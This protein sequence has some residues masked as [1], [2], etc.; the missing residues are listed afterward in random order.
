MNQSKDKGAHQISG[1]DSPIFDGRREQTLVIGPDEDAA[2]V[3]KEKNIDTEDI[4]RLQYGKVIVYNK[5]KRPCEECNVCCYEQGVIALKKY[6]ETAC[7]NSLANGKCRIYG[8]HPR[9]CQGYDCGHRLG[10]WDPADRPDKSGVLVSFY[11]NPPLQKPGLHAVV[12]LRKGH[13]PSRAGKMIADLVDALG[14]VKVLY[15]NREVTLFENGKVTLGKRL[16]QE[17]GMYEDLRIE[18][19]T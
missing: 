14:D 18:I 7:V 1:P 15:P 13:N 12:V 11:P 16:P 4:R 6:A 3:L 9:A 8:F 19:V 17:P 10:N 2:T 5:E